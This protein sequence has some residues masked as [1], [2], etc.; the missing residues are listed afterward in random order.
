M[1]NGTPFVMVAKRHAGTATSSHNEIYQMLVPELD[2]IIFNLI[3]DP[4]FR[5]LLETPSW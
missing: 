5:G 3:T 2:G 1:E 4:K